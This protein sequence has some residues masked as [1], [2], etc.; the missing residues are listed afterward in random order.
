MRLVFHTYTV[1]FGMLAAL[2]LTACRTTDTDRSREG[3]FDIDGHR[4]HYRIDGSGP[5]LVMLHGGYLDLTMWQ[6]QVERFK[7]DYRVIRYSDVGHGETETTGQPVAASAI[8]NALL[9]NTQTESATF[10]GLSWG[11]MLA[12]DYALL[13]PKR[14]TQLVL[15]SPGLN[16]WNYFRDTV[17]A[18]NY[19][20]RRAALKAGD[21]KLAARLFH[22][23]WVV[24][25][26]RDSS[27]L[28]PDFFDWS[29]AS[30][31]FNTRVHFGEDWSQIDT[32]PVTDRLSIV[33]VPTSLIVGDQDGQDILQ[34]TDVYATQLPRA[35]VYVVEGAAHLLSREK[36]EIF[37]AILANILSGNRP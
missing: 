12:I 34:I 14:I 1:C 30:I 19:A 28:A 13:H 31:A 21:F 15:I 7:P 17:A 3:F 18:T 9:E 2:L 11:A 6:P 27:S 29:L 32:L 33:D 24:G 35:E 10:I 4:I 5:D 16:G 25:P 20:N 22:Q 36:P 23:N 26:R 37:N 8:I